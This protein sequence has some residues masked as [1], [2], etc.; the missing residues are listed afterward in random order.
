MSHFDRVN[1]GLFLVMASVHSFFSCTESQRARNILEFNFL[2]TQ[3][4]LSPPD[5]AQRGSGTILVFVVKTL[6][7][8]IDS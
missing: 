5:D 6:A 4:G 7:N 1:D 3:Y 8:L 2:Y